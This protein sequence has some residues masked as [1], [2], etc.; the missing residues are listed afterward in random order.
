MRRFAVAG[1]GLALLSGVFG[2]CGGDD[3]A[4][5]SATVSPSAATPAGSAASTAPAGFKA[6]DAA[7]DLAPLGYTV[8]RQGKDP[9]AGSQ[10]V[11][12]VLFGKANGRSAMT[13]LYAFPDETIAKSQ[14]TAL[15][16]ALK[17]PPP[18]FVGS[19]ATFIDSTSPPVGDQQKAYVTQIPDGQ[20]NKVWSDIYRIGRLVAIVQLLDEG[21][22]EQ[23]D[24]RF[25]IGQ[26]IAAKVK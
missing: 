20:G 21:K 13:V 26:K 1:L 2:S 5:N 16:T 8:S 6:Q 19:K 7:P 25:Q 3:D 12:R 11:Y 24:L 14:F 9:G 23:L 4:P 22:S 15:S 17:N 18:D 10:D